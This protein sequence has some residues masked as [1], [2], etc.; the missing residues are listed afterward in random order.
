MVGTLHYCCIIIDQFHVLVP[1]L[2]LLSHQRVEINPG[3][4]VC[5]GDL[6]P[7]PQITGCLPPNYMEGSWVGCKLGDLRH[8]LSGHGTTAVSRGQASAALRG[9]HQA[10]WGGQGVKPQTHSLQPRGRETPLLRG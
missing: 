3:G 1:A 7:R 10:T 8:L 4:C 5:A 2:S 9:R 6:G